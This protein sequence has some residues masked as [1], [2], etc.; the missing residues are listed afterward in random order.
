MVDVITCAIFGDCRLRG[1][2]VVARR[3][4]PKT[5]YK[6]FLYKVDY[7]AVLGS[8][9][10]RLLV[11]AVRRSD[12]C[13]SRHN[14]HLCFNIGNEMENLVVKIQSLPN[15]PY[16]YQ[17]SAENFVQL[18]KINGKLFPTLEIDWNT[19][20]ISYVPTDTVMKLR[21]AVH[22]SYW[23][24]RKLRRI[25]NTAYWCYPI[26]SW[27]D[28]NIFLTVTKNNTASSDAIEPTAPDFSDGTRLSSTLYPSLHEQQQNKCMLVKCVM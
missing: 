28:K 18:S 22:L 5:L 12:Q 14:W 10:V 2:G 20:H 4:I 17:L 21:T 25:L 7:T 19:L 23:K 27:L 8:I 13:Y 16:C 3:V 24:A 11:M 6:I 26:A 15:S 9:L 1:V